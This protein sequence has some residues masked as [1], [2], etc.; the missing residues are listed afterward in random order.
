[1]GC[2]KR[3]ANAVRE[4]G[5][6]ITVVSRRNLDQIIEEISFQ[7]SDMADPDSQISL[8]KQLGADIILTGTITS[9]DEYNK[10]NAQ[11]IEVESAVVLG[12]FLMNFKENGD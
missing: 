7:M 2:D 9:G 8:G 1:M 11:L 10:I 12:G 6:D 3:V 4:E 5:M